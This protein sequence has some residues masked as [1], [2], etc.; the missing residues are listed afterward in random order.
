[1][2]AFIMSKF[3]GVTPDYLQWKCSYEEVL[4]WLDRAIE[5]HT[6]EYDDDPDDSDTTIDDELEYKGGRWVQKCQTPDK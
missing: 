4:L 2:L 5:I 3:P 6:G 1:M